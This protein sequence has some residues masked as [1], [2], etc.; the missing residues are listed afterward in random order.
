MIELN[1]TPRFLISRYK[2]T[3]LS[4]RLAWHILFGLFFLL[5]QAPFLLKIWNLW[6]TFFFIKIKEEKQ[7]TFPGI[8]RLRWTQKFL[9]HTYTYFSEDRGSLQRKLIFKRTQLVIDRRIVENYFIHIIIFRIMITSIWKQILS[10]RTNI[11]LIISWRQHHFFLK[12]EFKMV[13]ILFG[14][15]WI[16]PVLLIFTL[17]ITTG[18]IYFIKH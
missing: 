18:K 2:F 13:I 12:E 4:A 3:Q 15:I 1:P 6:C 14:D 7:K 10:K 11:R 8:Q 9:F 17:K 5:L 16:F